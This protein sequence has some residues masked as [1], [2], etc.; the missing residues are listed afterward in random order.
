MNVTV[1]IRAAVDGDLTALL[2]QPMVEAAKRARVAARKEFEG[3]ADDARK[4]GDK[5]AQ[6]SG[7]GGYRTQA[8]DDAQGG[9]AAR[10]K[11]HVAIESEEDRHNREMAKKSRDAAREIVSQKKQAERELDHSRARVSEG[12]VRNFGGLARRATGV[13]G[14]IARGAGIDFNIGS[15][16]KSRF[17]LEKRAT[18]LS[19]AAFMPGDKGVAGKR[20]DP[21][22]IMSEVQAVASATALDTNAAMEGLQA[23]VGKTGDLATGRAVLKDMAIMARATGGELGDIVSAAGDVSANLGEVGD[24]FKT[25]EDKAR[26][27]SAVMHAMAAQGKVGAVEMKD[28]ASQMAKLASSAPQFAGPVEDSMASMGAL[29]QMAR[30]KGGAASATQATTSVQG[31]VNTFGKAA[32]RKEFKD[33]GINIEDAKTG[34]LLDPEEI[35]V[36]ALKKTGGSKAKMNKL[37]MDAGAQRVTGGFRNI[38]TQAEAKEKGSG[39]AA[40]RAEFAK[41]KKANMGA[42]ETS[43]S[44]KAS[45]ATNEAKAAELKA[46]IEKDLGDAVERLA[47]QMLKLA[48]RVGQAVEAFGGLVVWAANNPLKAAFAGFGASVMKSIGE[49]LMRTS[50]SRVFGGIVGGGGGGTP[51][52]GGAVGTAGAALAIAAMAV[53]TFQVGTLLVDQMVDNSKKAE[54]KL[55]EQDANAM[56][57]ESRLAVAQGKADDD[58]KKNG[59]VSPEVQANLLAAQEEA[60]KSQETFSKRTNEGADFS[61]QGLPEKVLRGQGAALNTAL[62]FMGF[63]ARVGKGETLS[64]LKDTQISSEHL[65]SMSEQLTR[66]N[67]VIAGGIKISSLPAGMPG[68]PNAV[69]KPPGG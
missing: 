67:Q 29:A 58:I 37:F 33:A 1:R 59:F 31:F 64:E 36:N 39:E 18:D 13:A 62:Q 10:R 47:P 5:A 22:A 53:T 40:V 14:D 15:A 8:P 49:E 63:D 41:L 34:A 54:D 28:L 11:A 17:D 65:S 69:T 68:L 42:T 3:M 20:Q 12:T 48:P 52:A 19:N 38:F 45:M 7:R 44:F 56:N 6:R 4:A 35:I 46:K 24:K 30:A 57:A 61:A 51:G 60:A 16:A 66:L 27:V 32:R 23:F 50:V 2:Y 26:A 25:S 43:D 21:R 9:V 55:T